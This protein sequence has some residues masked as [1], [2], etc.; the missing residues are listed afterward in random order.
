MA[1]AYSASGAK[2]NQVR[3]TV[4]ENKYLLSPP[5]IDYRPATTRLPP[6]AAT[7]SPSSSPVENGIA[8]EAVDQLAKHIAKL[9]LFRDSS[10]PYRLQIPEVSPQ[11]FE[12]C[13]ARLLACPDESVAK[14]YLFC[15][16]DQQLEEMTI[17]FQLVQ[18]AS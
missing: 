18:Q 11:L 5:Q 17:T 1:T 16:H 13:K 4:A 7:P 12:S 8:N 9:V 14:T 6:I 2:G 10:A 3:P 15:E